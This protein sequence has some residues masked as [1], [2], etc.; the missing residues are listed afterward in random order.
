MPEPSKMLRDSPGRR[1]R[2]RTARA[3]A[4]HR[5]PAGHES[6]LRGERRR[7]AVDKA[8]ELKPD[9]VVMDISM[10][11]M[12]GLLATRT[13]KE[14][15]P[16]AAIITLTRHGDDAAPARTAA[17]GRIRLRPQAERTG[18][19][20][21]GDPRGRRGGQHLD[22]TLTARVTAGFLAKDGKG[23]GSRLPPSARGKPTCCG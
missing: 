7:S 11:G 23:W 10:P 8:L 12:N 9:V 4:A 2:H 20:A 21:P 13:L 3:Q 6:D 14:R 16:G 19:A 5:K 22:S 15:Q 1:S 17:R 18:G